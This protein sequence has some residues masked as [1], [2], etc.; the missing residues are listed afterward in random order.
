MPMEMS[1]FARCVNELSSADTNVKRL[2]TQ[3]LY[4][5]ITGVA[6]IDEATAATAVKA[7]GAAI[8][9]ALP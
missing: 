3:R 2:A 8:D 5:L 4:V 6:A 7:M 9:A 1:E